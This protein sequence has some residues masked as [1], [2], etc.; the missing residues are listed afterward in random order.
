M[1]AIIQSVSFPSCSRVVHPHELQE[2]Q[3]TAFSPCYALFPAV[4][5]LII[6]FSCFL[7]DPVSRAGINFRPQKKRRRSRK[8]VYACFRKRTF[9]QDRFCL[10]SEI[11]IREKKSKACYCGSKWRSRITQAKLTKNIRKDLGKINDLGIRTFTY[12]SFTMGSFDDPIMYLLIAA[13]Q[14]RW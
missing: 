6:I 12:Y 7:D 11:D 4:S 3:K 13:W 5:G 9:F 14:T 10:V 8:K 1:T 2:S